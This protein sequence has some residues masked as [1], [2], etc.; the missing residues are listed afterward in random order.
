MILTLLVSG[1]GLIITA[2]INVLATTLPAGRDCPVFDL[3]AIA[4]VNQVPATA[5]LFC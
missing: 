1:I 4:F 3:L 2:N 5:K